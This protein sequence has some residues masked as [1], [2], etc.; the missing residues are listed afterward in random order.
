MGDGYG[1]GFNRRS[2]M[3]LVAG[4]AVAA[5]PVGFA[6]FAS[7][8]D[9]GASYA[10]DA[11]QL[12]DLVFENYAY[13]E[14][15][16]GFS[17]RRLA[18]LRLEAP[19]VDSGRALIGFGE[20][21][22]AALFDHHAILG[23][24]TAD[25]Y[26]LVPS[27][28]DL[29]IASDGVGG[30]VIE[31]V[32]AGS[33]ALRAGV[34]PGDALVGVGDESIDAAISAFIEAPVSELD[35]EQR[36]WCA[37]VLSV[38]RRDRERVLSFARD[39]QRRRLSLPNLYETP[40]ERGDGLISTRELG[41]GVMHIRFNNSLGESEA[42]AAFDAAMMQAHGA[43]GVVIDL[44][45]T[46]SGGNTVVARG[47][48]GWFVSEPRFYQRHE[49]VSETRQTGIRRSWVEEVSPRP[50]GQFS[51]RAVALVGRWTGS[52]GEGMAIGFDAIGVH[53]VGARM[54]GLRGAVYDFPLSNSGMV[55]KLPAERLWHVDG[56]PR[57]L[58]M[59]SE[60]LAFA[61]FQENGR[62]VA[63]EHALTF[64]RSA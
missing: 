32:R 23:W 16:A 63:L 48:L 17:E 12:I 61:D 4:G 2:V 36:A 22:L 5:S 19:D 21:A 27:F 31:D 57:E 35:A 58:F 40:V 24:S 14:R 7:E 49:L 46:P 25:S 41:D 28:A 37:R 56:T 10:A 11:L 39:G 6:A 3:A 42:V 20:R 29:W 1:G 47:V 51:G 44:R 8:Q 45:D 54:A 34:R 59:P 53:V 50:I 60:A 43:R 64:V 18:A 9:D 38:G 55:V 33:P 15:L 13:P 62:D 52:M 26:G 30:Y